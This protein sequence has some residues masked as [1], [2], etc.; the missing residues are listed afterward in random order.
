[1]TPV[2]V[3]E[4]GKRERTKAQNRATILDAARD[5]FAELGYGAAT[6]RDVVRRTDLAA[7]TFYNY[8]PD[9][10]AVLRALVEENAAVIRGRLRAARGAATTREQF[11]RDGYHVYFA[12]VLEDRSTFELMRRN[13]ETI[14]EL[15]HEPALGAGVDDLLADLRRAIDS[16]LLPALDADYMAA[17]MAGVGIEVGMRMVEREP[18]DVEAAT[19]FATDLF[20][21]AIERM[22]RAARA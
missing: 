11:V 6:V 21:G 3:A 9:K 8:F 14:R 22:E 12:Y 18:P 1:M 20:L 7:G 19:A 4:R 16:G 15:I 5:V 13:A 17:A 2:S 10:E